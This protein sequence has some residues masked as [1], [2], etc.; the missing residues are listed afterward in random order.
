MNRR[1]LGYQ[2]NQRTC[3]CRNKVKARFRDRVKVKNKVKERLK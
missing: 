3:E 1:H 2:A